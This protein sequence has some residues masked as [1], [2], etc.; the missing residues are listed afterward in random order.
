MASPRIL[1]DI[2]LFQAPV[3]TVG[4]RFIG[5][6]ALLGIGFVCSH[7]VTVVVTCAVDGFDWG[8]TAW[9]LDIL[10]FLAGF[11]FAIQCWQS[12]N[13][14]SIDFKRE[15]SWICVWAFVTFATRILDTL[16][17]FGLVTWSA[18]YVTPTGPTLW[19]NVMSEIVFGMT[20][21]VAAL[22]GSLML[23]TDPENGTARSPNR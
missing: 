23:L 10:G 18:V 4:H 1:S 17:L 14:K 19:S 16:M 7:I 11:F 22:V 5:V 2:G 9:V 3:I 15:N 20:F 21:C 13:R 6:A 12:S 8:V